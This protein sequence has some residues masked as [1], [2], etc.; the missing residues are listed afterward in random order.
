M[1]KASL[2]LVENQKQIESKINKALKKEVDAAVAKAARRLKAPITELLR[3]AILSQPEV[4]SLQGSGQLAAE[5]GL[6]DGRRRISQLIDIWTQ[7]IKI[8]KKNAT[9]R[10]SQIN[11]GLSVTMVQRDFEDVIQSEA[12][13]VRTA[14]G[15]ELPWLE[16]LL[17]FGDRIIIRDYDVSFNRG[18]Q[19][20]SR[21]GLAV[22]VKGRGKRWRVPPQ[23]SG[24]PRNNFVT[25]ALESI[26]EDVSKL[27]EAQLKAAV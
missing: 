14:K 3:N 25:R 6:P 15:Q 27:V 10:G 26:D 22:M 24:T 12:A 4:N 20:R 16:W 7:G 21:S 1:V 13:I 9:V 19:K 18:Q 23:F 17:R 2:T 5:F 8:V 11:A